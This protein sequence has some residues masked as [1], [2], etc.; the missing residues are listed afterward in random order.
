MQVWIDESGIATRPPPRCCLLP[1]Y[2]TRPF[3]PNLSPNF[4]VAPRRSVVVIR[5]DTD[6]D[7]RELELMQW[8]LKAWK[9]IPRVG[10][11][12]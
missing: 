7:E 1:T 12:Y 4:N 6:R 3:M 10:N 5:A 11:L 8:G 2:R 9:V